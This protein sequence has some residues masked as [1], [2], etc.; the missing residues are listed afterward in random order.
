MKITKLL[1]AA[2]MVLTC[3]VAS[4]Q[5]N[6]KKTHMPMKQNM[7]M[8]MMSKTMMMGLTSGEKKIAMSHMAHMTPAEKSVMM[9]QCQM[10]MKDKHAG[11]MDKKMTK[12]MEMDHMMSGLSMAEQKTMNGMWAKMSAQ[13]KMVGKKMMMNCCKYGMKHGM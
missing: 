2:L 1:C 7:K 12:Q 6:M 3:C 8:D 11:M 10:C 9:K 5:T 13:E 4:A